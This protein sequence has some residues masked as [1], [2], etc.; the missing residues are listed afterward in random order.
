MYTFGHSITLETVGKWLGYSL[1]V[2][3]RR[4]AARVWGG[5]IIS[6]AASAVVLLNGSLM[7]MTEDSEDVADDNYRSRKTL[8]PYVVIYV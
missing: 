8:P 4:H 2:N 6:S 1:C 7:M 5:S 3:K